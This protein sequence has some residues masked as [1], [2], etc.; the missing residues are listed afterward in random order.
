MRKVNKIWKEEEVWLDDSED[1]FS[2][3][4]DEIIQKLQSIKEDLATRGY[5]NIRLN[6]NAGYEN[7]SHSAYGKRIETDKEFERRMKNREAQKQKKLRDKDK[8]KDRE[9]KELER[10]KKKYEKLGTKIKDLS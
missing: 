5:K 9:L 8:K 7:I 3:N 1:I 6:E 4:I 2:G 10:L